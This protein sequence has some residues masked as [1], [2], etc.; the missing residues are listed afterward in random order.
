MFTGKEQINNVNKSK[1][2]IVFIIAGVGPLFQTTNATEMIAELSKLHANGGDDEPE[3]AWS[4]ILL[5]VNNVRPGSTCYFFTDASAKDTDLIPTVQA[6]VLE[7]RV[8]VMKDIFY[9]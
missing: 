2:E 7:K 9:Y 4:G 3:L 1:N 6:K 8:R 5:A